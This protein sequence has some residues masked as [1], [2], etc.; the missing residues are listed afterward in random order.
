MVDHVDFEM[1]WSRQVS[2]QA[3]GAD[4]AGQG[5]RWRVSGP[6]RTGL[7]AVV[8]HLLDQYL[9]HGDGGALHTPQQVLGELHLTLLGQT[10]DGPDQ[11]GI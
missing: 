2:W 8:A 6:T 1:A 10:P 4:G 7:I 9:H 11:S 3:T 5:V